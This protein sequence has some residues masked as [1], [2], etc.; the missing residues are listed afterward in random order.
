MLLQDVRSNFVD[1]SITA[2]KKSK[3][4]TLKAYSLTIDEVLNDIKEVEQD[5]IKMFN[6]L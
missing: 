2:E 5:L 6:A 4:W 1:V 3:W